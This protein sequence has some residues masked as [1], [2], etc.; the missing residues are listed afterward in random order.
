MNW[1][2]VVIQV[3]LAASF[4]SVFSEMRADKQNRRANCFHTLSSLCFWRNCLRPREQSFADWDSRGEN[5]HSSR[6]FAIH[7]RAS[8]DESFLLHWQTY[9][10]LTAYL[11]IKSAETIRPALI[12]SF[13]VLHEAPKSIAIP[14]GWNISLLQ[15]GYDPITNVTVFLWTLFYCY[16]CHI[17]NFQFSYLMH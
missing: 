17:Y 16:F 14:R 5:S 2:M 15:P 7:I 10:Q 13:L 12:S 8:F 4:T 1:S 11:M 9:Q 3:I 6:R